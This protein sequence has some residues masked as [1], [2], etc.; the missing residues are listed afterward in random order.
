MCSKKKKKD[1]KTFKQNRKKD[2]TTSAFLEMSLTSLIAVS[3]AL[4]L[5][6]RWTEIRVVNP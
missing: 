6:G 4:E 1:E 5:D 2:L 3:P